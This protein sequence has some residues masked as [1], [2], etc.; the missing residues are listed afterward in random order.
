MPMMRDAISQRCLS[1]EKYIGLA[2]YSLTKTLPF[3]PLENI[4]KMVK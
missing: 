3:D 2:H 1:R 4:M